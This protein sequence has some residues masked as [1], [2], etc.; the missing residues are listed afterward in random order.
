[1]YRQKVRRRIYGPDVIA[2]L[3]KDA[4]FPRAIAFCLRELGASLAVLPRNGEPLKK[5][6]ELRRMLALLEVQR[7]PIAALHQW[8]DD[9]QLK[10]ERA[11]RSRRRHVVCAVDERAGKT[12]V[13]TQSQ[14]QSQRRSSTGVTGA[15]TS[16]P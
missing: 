10:L 9:T 1:M 16:R 8:I 14:T 5:L 12:P 4:Q 2:Y 15:A 3:L 11:A 6:G 13:T 7:A